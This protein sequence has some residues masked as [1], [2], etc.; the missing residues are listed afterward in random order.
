MTERHRSML[1]ASP[2]ILQKPH[3]RDEVAQVMSSIVAEPH[4]RTSPLLASAPSSTQTA[5]PALHDV[6]GVKPGLEHLRRFQP[7]APELLA[8]PRR[9]TP[10]AVGLVVAVAVRAGLEAV[11]VLLLRQA[12]EDDQGEAGAWGPRH[13]REEERWD[14]GFDVGVGG[15]EG[16]GRTVQVGS[17]EAWRRWEGCR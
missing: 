1:P 16:L 4:I 7:L 9:Q 2:P 6:L 13:G 15:R 8:L 5:P 10:L 17:W 14:G 12:E 11:A 3:I